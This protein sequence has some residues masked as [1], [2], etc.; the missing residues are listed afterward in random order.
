M[1]RESFS[2]DIDFQLF[3]CLNRPYIYNYMCCLC[4]RHQWATTHMLD[5][6]FFRPQI[7]NPRTLCLFCFW[8]GQ[9]E[10]SMHIFIYIFIYIYISLYTHICICMRIFTYL[11]C[12]LSV[13]QH[14][15]RHVHAGGAFGSHSCEPFSGSAHE[16]SKI[17]WLIG[18]GTM[19]HTVPSSQ[20]VSQGIRNSEESFENAEY[21]GQNHFG[22][23]AKRWGCRK[24]SRMHCH[25]GIPGMHKYQT[26][27]LC[28]VFFSSPGSRQIVS[29]NA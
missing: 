5:V 14:M 7:Q 8:Q 26:W 11:L 10:F 13:R 12:I 29:T 17:L 4:R 23:H 16:K 15:R 6:I 2:V 9:G 27:R 24:G 28:N 3:L 22:V 1:V 19:G 25:L 18:A 21:G 20:G